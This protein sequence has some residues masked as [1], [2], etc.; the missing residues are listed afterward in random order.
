MWELNSDADADSLATA[1]I[2]DASDM[3]TWYSTTY[4]IRRNG[5]TVE[6]NVVFSGR[7]TI[8]HLIAPAGEGLIRKTDDGGV[9]VVAGSHELLYDVVAGTV[10]IDGQALGKAIGGAQ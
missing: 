4:G 9:T 6:V 2:T 7:A 3:R 8:V 10:T 5:T 1:L